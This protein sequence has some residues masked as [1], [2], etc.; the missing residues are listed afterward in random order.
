MGGALGFDGARIAITEGV[1]K[2]EAGGVHADVVHG[3]SVDGDGANTFGGELSA[4]AHAFLNAADDAVQVPAQAAI[5]LAGVVGEAVHQFDG[6]AAVLPAQQGDAAT[7][8]AE[9]DGD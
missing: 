7:L 9:I 4:A 8:R 5:D 2:R 6:R 1:G 3:P